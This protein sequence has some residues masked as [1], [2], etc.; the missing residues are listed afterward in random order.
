MNFAPEFLDEIRSRIRVS[1]IVGKRIKLLKRGNEFLAVC[2]FHNDTKPSLSIVDDKNFYHCFACGAHGDIIKFTM[3][4]EG[5][6][7]PETIEKLAAIAGLEM[8]SQTPEMRLREKRRKTLKDVNEEACRFYEKLLWSSAG[9]DGLF[10]L[11][12]RGLSDNVI[13][14]YRLGFSL[15][16]RHSLKDAMS[17]KGIDLSLLTEAGLVRVSEQNGDHYDYFRNRVM[18]PISDRRGQVIAFGARTIGESQPKYLNSP[19]TPLFQKGRILYGISQ[20]RESSSQQKEIIVT[21]GYMDVIAL[22]EAG[23]TNAVAPLGTALTEDQINELWRLGKEPFICFDGDE[24]GLQAAVRAADRALPVLKPGHSLCFSILPPGEDPDDLIKRLGIGAFKDVLTRSVSL[25]D[26]IWDQEFRKR[27]TN[28]PERL[29]DFFKRIRGK[30]KEISDRGVQEAYRDNI[31]Q[32]I[33]Q[34]REHLNGFKKTKWENKSIYSRKKWNRPDPFDTGSSKI[35]ASNVMATRQKQIILAAFIN[36]PG[37][38]EDFGE[39]LGYLDFVDPFLDKLRLDILDITT[40]EQ[41]LEVSE[42]QNHLIRR[43]YDKEV[44]GILNS[45]VLRHAAFARSNASE[46]LAKSGVRELL[47]RIGK[48]QL[49]EQLSAAQKVVEQEFNEINWNRLTSLRAALVAVNDSS[50]VEDVL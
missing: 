17:Q 4:T 10:Y 20:A 39:A 22:A 37:L 41:G 40:M 12:N 36:H 15:G 28:T 19:E 35:N 48:Y 1:E 13:K 25:A 23:I 18:F 16:G 7:F 49:E 43:G 32:K 46:A 9:Q 14:K 33:R 26:F 24:A 30:V 42:I 31:E 21:E 47:S 8:P 2:P 44:G 5:L 50:N 3:E 27:Q 6:N 45:R 34:L 38:V 11:K 29:A